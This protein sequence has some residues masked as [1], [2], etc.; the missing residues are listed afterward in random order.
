MFKAGQASGKSGSFFFFSHDKRFI[1]K[2]IS[3]ED[4][5]TSINFVPKYFEHMTNN[6]EAI[7]A[8][9]YGIFSL[10]MKGVIPLPFILMENTLNFK[11][12]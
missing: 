6:P 2:T 8:K 10:K 12:V 1:I 7:L 9:I 5:R 4:L 11:G 3:Q